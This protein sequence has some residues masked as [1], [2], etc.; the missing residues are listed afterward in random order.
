VYFEYAK[1]QWESDQVSINLMMYG[2]PVRLVDADLTVLESRF[3]WGQQ[4][5]TLLL[6]RSLDFSSALKCS[7]RLTR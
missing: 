7:G 6:R 4:M 2:V 5:A 3:V 1:V